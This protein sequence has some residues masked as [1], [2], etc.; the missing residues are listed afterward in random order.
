[1]DNGNLDRLNE[2]EKRQ[3]KE[4]IHYEK[5]AKE[6]PEEHSITK[7]SQFVQDKKEEELG[8]CIVYSEPS[9]NFNINFK[10]LKSSLKLIM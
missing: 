4:Q 2:R 10:T 1:M 6:V 8:K 7:N 3:E 5:F 9:F